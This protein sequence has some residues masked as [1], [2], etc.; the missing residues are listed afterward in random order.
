MKKL[1]ILLISILTAGELISQARFIQAGK[2]EFERKIN[3]H[4]QVDPTDESS[5]W[6]KDFIKQQPKFHTTYFD[7]YFNQNKTL[8]KPGRET[9]DNRKQLW[10]IGPSKDN[11]VALDLETGYQ[12]NRKN[13]FEATYLLQDTSRKI[14]WKL[15][16]EIRTI[17]GFDCRKAVGRICDSVYVV[18]FY[19]EEILSN[20]GPESFNGL[21]GMILGIAIPRLYT[22]WYATK[23]ELIEPTSKDLDFPAKGKKV[24]EKELEAMLQKS[25][26]D[27]G[28]QA[29]RNIWWVML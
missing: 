3:V 27:W 9:D 22:T 4:R 5:D 29:Q 6:F 16:D 14:E 1:I 25:L 8:Y 13:I 12:K 11:E 7:L 23:L 19:T 10:F 28:K 17:A 2:I 15:E 21:P 26:S 18:A 24:T 20:G